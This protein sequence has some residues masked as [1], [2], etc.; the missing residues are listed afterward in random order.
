LEVLQGTIDRA[1]FL[2]VLDPS[3]EYD[4]SAIRRGAPRRLAR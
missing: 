3:Q 2:V 1:R 4:G